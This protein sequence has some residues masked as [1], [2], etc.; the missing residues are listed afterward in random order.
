M[1]VGAGVVEPVFDAAVAH[2][3]VQAGPRL[4]A[5]TAPYLAA[6]RL[7]TWVELELDLEAS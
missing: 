4:R 6:L 3:H 7:T 2:R 5:V 1:H